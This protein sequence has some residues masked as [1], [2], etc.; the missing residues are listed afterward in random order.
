MSEIL[1]IVFAVVL[2]IITIILSIVGIQIILVLI[3]VKR[4]LKK[5][6]D[7]ATG[8]EN[9]FNQIIA[10]L[11]NLGGMASG[12]KTGFSLFESFVQWLNRNKSK[13]EA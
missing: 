2:V 8:I 5:V 6:N 4:T 10:P 13:K 9:K 11:Q 7:T 3:E 12:L 1:P